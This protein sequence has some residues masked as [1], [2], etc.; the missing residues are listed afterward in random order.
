M[1]AAAPPGPPAST[2]APAATRRRA[3]GERHPSA[4][5]APTMSAMPAPR[6][7]HRT[8]T[9]L[10]SVVMLVLGVAMIV[11]TVTVGGGPIAIG[12]ILGMLF[13]LAGAGRLWLA[14]G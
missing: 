11:R 13:I 14:R 3:A 1:A 2:A 6:D 4:R 5:D 9:R 10:F 7:V 8:T 12:V